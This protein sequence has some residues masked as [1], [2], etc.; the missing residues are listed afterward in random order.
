MEGR[1]SVKPLLCTINATKAVEVA[2]SESVSKLHNDGAAMWPMGWQELYFRTNASDAVG[3]GKTAI[4]EAWS[5]YKAA[6]VVN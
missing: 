1:H 6:D 2:V 3:P 5:K 4:I